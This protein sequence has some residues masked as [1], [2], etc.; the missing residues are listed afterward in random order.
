MSIVKIQE[1]GQS[2]TWDITDAEVVA[3]QYGQQVKFSEQGGDILYMPHE[4]AERQLD[5]I[6]LTVVECAGKRLTI[7]RDPNPKP[8]S[9]PYWGIRLGGAAQAPSKRIPS[10]D[11]LPAGND[12]VHPF[13][14]P[15]EEERFAAFSD[16]VDE[17]NEGFE[18]AHRAAP[19]VSGKPTVAN[20]VAKYAQIFHAL[21]VRLKAAY[22]VKCPPEVVQS[23]TATVWIDAKNRGLV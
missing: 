16:A 5:R 19:S 7:S 8:G 4:S 23:A 17:V 10:P 15:T 1:A 6:G 22:G 18:E 11:S 3:G 21:D 12:A 13:D 14:E 9:K 2:V 20:L